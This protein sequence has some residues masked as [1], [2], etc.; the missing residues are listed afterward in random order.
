MRRFWKDTRGN[1]AI[2]F[3]LTAIPVF[4][5]MG[6]AVDYSR[7]SSLHTTLRTKAD[8]AAINAAVNGPAGD[9]QGIVA[10]LVD[11]ITASKGDGVVSDVHASGQWVGSDFVVVASARMA[12]AIVHVVPG[13]SDGMEV[14]VRAVARRNEEELFYK[15]PV[16]SDLDPEASDYN[17][18]YVYCFDPEGPGFAELRRSQMTL[19]ADNAGS[20]FQYQWP[21]CRSGET[22]S[23][24]LRNVRDAR[25]SPRRWND[26]RAE[27]YDFYT[28]T[29]IVG[30]VEHYALDY[31][32]LETV[33]C[34]TF[35]ECVPV[36]QG[37]VLPEGKERTP[38]KSDEPCAAG[39][40]MYYGWE[41]RP[42]GLGWTDR[43][44]DDIRIIM[45][46]PESG[47]LGERLVR[48][49]E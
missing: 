17:Q 4:G 46:C 1:V 21:K 34:D 31:E 3:G 15:E 29:V 45:Q 48:L 6:A 35:E 23:F 10:R 47:V 18:I 11:E 44:Y 8:E 37:G 40:Y 36:S 38:K 24:R 28:D 32:I 9:H 16:L 5:L 30:G 12:T 19:I 39:T 25:T 43:D 20:N 49:V 27:Q 41:D 42:P 2:I 22:M 14:S 13:I 33:R 26:P 7:A